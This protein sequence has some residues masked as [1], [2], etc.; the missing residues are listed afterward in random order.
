VGRV[1]AVV[2]IGLIIGTAGCATSPPSAQRSDRQLVVIGSANRS[3]AMSAYVGNVLSPEQLRQCV[4][5]DRQYCGLFGR[6]QGTNVDL[7]LE[8]ERTAIQTEDTVLQAEVA[9]ANRHSQAAVDAMNAR[10]RKHSERV[11]AYNQR[12]AEYSSLVNSM[13]KVAE[14]FNAACVGKAFYMDDLQ[15]V[16]PGWTQCPGAT[17]AR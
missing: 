3:T 8:R 7:D 4:T 12:V 10:I 2:L 14:D 11:N 16:S 9:V 13:N 15:Q 17:V 5:L 1:L 6:V